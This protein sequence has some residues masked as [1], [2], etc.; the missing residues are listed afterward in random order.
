[1][2]MIISFRKYTLMSHVTS[3]IFNSF[4]LYLLLYMFYFI[5][6][7]YIVFAYFLLYTYIKM[8][9]FFYSIMFN[10]F[11]SVYSLQNNSYFNFSNFL[12]VI[13]YVY[14]YIHFTI[15]IHLSVCEGVEKMKSEEH[16]YVERRKSAGKTNESSIV[17]LQQTDLRVSQKGG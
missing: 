17:N 5:L 1:M 2:M 7:I 8:I 6:Q 14:M 9:S 15:Y 13:L 10:S 12:I 3:R 16:G 11:H 4:L